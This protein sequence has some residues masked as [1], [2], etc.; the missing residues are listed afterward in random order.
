[1]V[2][3]HVQQIELKALLSAEIAIAKTSKI[4][5]VHTYSEG[6]SQND[7]FDH[8]RTSITVS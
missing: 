5:V 4:K 8:L 1:M 7:K 6:I 2:R 3:K